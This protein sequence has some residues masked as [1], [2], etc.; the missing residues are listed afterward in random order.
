MLNWPA[1]DHETGDFSKCWTLDD[2][3]NEFYETEISRRFSHMSQP[4]SQ[5]GDSRIGAVLIVKQGILNQGG[6]ADIFLRR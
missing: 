3:G 1:R 2:F 5:L 4:V 6:P